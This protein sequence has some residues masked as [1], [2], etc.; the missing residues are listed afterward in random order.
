MLTCS[1]ASR[2]TPDHVTSIGMPHQNFKVASPKPNFRIPPR[3]FNKR[4]LHTTLPSRP[5][6][7]QRQA[8]TDGER[9]HVPV[10]KTFRKGGRRSLN[11]QNEHGPRPAHPQEPRRCNRDR[12]KSEPQAKRSRPRS[13]PRYGKSD[14]PNIEKGEGSD[15]RGNGSQNGS[16]T[17]EASAGNS[18]GKEA[19]GHAGRRD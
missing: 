4:L 11:L 8:E 10:C 16:G 3:H 6:D 7:A 12:R 1:C 2:Q 18:R 14:R 15:G 19:E 13:R 9:S 5:H 17:D